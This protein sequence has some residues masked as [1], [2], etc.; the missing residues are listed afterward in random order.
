MLDYGM[1]SQTFANYST[2]RQNTIDAMESVTISGNKP[3]DALDTLQ[4][5][6]EAL[7]QEN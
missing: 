6:T 2:F 3:Q 5:Q 7:Y 4:K 1:A